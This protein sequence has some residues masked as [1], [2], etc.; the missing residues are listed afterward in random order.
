VLRLNKIA[1]K[2]ILFVLLAVFGSVAPS[3]AAPREEHITL[4]MSFAWLGD[5]VAANIEQ[6]FLY[7]VGQ[8]APPIKVETVRAG[9]AYETGIACDS[10]MKQDGLHLIVFAGD[11]GCAAVAAL[12]SAEYKIPVLK[13]TNDFRSFSRLSGSFFEFLPSAEAQ[14]SHLA[15]FAAKTLDVAGTLALCPQD[16]RGRA[17]MDGFRQGM[18]ESGKLLEASKYYAPDAVSIRTEVEGLFADTVRLSH[19]GGRVGSALSAEERTELFGDSQK[20]E[21]LFSSETMDSAAVEITKAHEAFLFSIS[22]DKIDSYAKQLPEMPQGTVLLG[23]SG[24]LDLDALNRQRKATED[25]YIV[26]PLLP[27]TADTS[28][29]FRGY[30]ITRSH[31]ISPWELLGLDAGQFVA[32]VLAKQPKTR[33]EVMKAMA[34]LKFAGRAVNVDFKGGHENRRARMMRFENG[35]VITIE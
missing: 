31:E 22:P 6:S 21:V 5:S 9:S 20:G 27:E 34:E 2:L 30:K 23:N 4:L 10:I 24:W 16:A 33:S 32:Q 14:S 26:V 8:S 12:K 13:L 15:E 1:Q 19:G 29:F 11:E 3:V 18:A 25:M 7:A 35:N 28:E 17:T